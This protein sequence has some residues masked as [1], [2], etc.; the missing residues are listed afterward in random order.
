LLLLFQLWLEQRPERRA[1]EKE[2][3][4]QKMQQMALIKG[5]TESRSASRKRLK[6]E[7]GMAWIRID[8]D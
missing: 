3:R 6:H 1:K 4:K 5:F 2:K 7:Q 8:F